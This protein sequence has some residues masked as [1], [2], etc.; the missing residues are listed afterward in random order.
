MRGLKPLESFLRPIEQLSEPDA[1][2]GDLGGAESLVLVQDRVAASRVEIGLALL[3]VEDPDFACAGGD[4][5]SLPSLPVRRICRWRTRSRSPSRARRAARGVYGLA[6]ALRTKAS[7]VGSV[8][9]VAE[10]VLL[11]CDDFAGFMRLEVQNEHRNKEVTQCVVF[12][13]VS[14]HVDQFS[15]HQFMVMRPRFRRSQNPRLSD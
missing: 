10:S 5:T 12:R 15:V 8:R 9:V 4:G 6:V 1:E 11:L 14:R 7:Y 2:T 13:C 3:D